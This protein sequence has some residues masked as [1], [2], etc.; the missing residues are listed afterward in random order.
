MHELLAILGC[1]GTKKLAEVQTVD[2]NIK[3][4]QNLD[5]SSLLVQH[6]KICIPNSQC[7]VR[8]DKS[9]GAEKVDRFTIHG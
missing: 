1:T 7:T 8:S 2:G 4:K 5:Q 3:V 6:L 9:S